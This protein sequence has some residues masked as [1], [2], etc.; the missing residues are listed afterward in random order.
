MGMIA[1]QL[2]DLKLGELLDTPPPGLDEAVATAKVGVRVFVCGVMLMCVYV[3]LCMSADVCVS[4]CVCFKAH[5]TPST[6]YSAL[7]I[8]LH[9]KPP[10][11]T[12]PPR[13]SPPPG[14]PVCRVS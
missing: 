10:S 11:S 6:P 4:V 12:F 7:S 9:C 2:A 13:S 14:G 5:V 8:M 1:N 3:C